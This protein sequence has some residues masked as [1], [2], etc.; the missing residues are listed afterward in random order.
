VSFCTE[1]NGCA[2]GFGKFKMAGQ[3]VCMKVRFKYV[4]NS[5]IQFACAVK[6][7]VNVA[8]WVYDNCAAS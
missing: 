7:L 2:C 6:V 1:T 4:G 8:L 3:E 5:E